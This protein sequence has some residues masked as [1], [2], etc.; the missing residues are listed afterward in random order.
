MDLESFDRPIE[1]IV[2]LEYWGVLIVRFIGPTTKHV[3]SFTC[4]PRVNRFPREL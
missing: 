3:R 4:F 2:V 1:Q